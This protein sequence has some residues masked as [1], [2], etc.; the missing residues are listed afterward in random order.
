MNVILPDSSRHTT[1]PDPRA[2][3]QVLMELGINPLDVIVVV[4][5]RLVPEDTV[6]SGNDEVRII[7]I[8]HGG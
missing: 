5:G 6:I 7:R 1:T 2:V 3:D 4:N 8:A